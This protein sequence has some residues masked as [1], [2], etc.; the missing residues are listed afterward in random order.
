M[1]IERSFTVLRGRARSKVTLSLRI[2]GTR[3]DGFHELDALAVSCSEPH[4]DVALYPQRGGTTMSVIPAGAAP[5]RVAENLAGRA[6]EALR[7]RL[8]ATV[9]G[10]RVRLRKHIP[11]AA[12]LGGGSADAAEVL[13]LLGSH[14]G[15]RRRDLER[16]AA[17]LGS[18]VPFALRGAPSFLRGRGERL[19]PAAGIPSLALVIAT[20][21]FGCSTP[22]VYR[23]WD[24]LGAPSSQR[25][26]ESPL[27]AEGL[28]NDLEPAALFVAP[29]L[30]TFRDSFAR[31]ARRAPLLLGS[32]SSYAVIAD[33]DEHASA[34]ADRARDALR[35][36]T[37][38]AG[39]SLASR[40]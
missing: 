39:S 30:Q 26:V 38:W 36:A 4:D 11:V 25:V 16:V 29:A 19:G 21:P 14:F 12:G 7:Q 15:I 23:A 35:V 28:A 31:V 17:R 10:V 1:T 37:V 27:L 13:A 8:P 3:A 34:L 22:E 6:V 18:D 32:G 40:R 5:S 33:D 24:E 9:A 2:L 20:P